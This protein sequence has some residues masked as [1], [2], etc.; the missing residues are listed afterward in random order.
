M[1]S[2]VRISHRLQ[3]FNVLLLQHPSFISLCFI[4]V[5]HTTPRLKKQNF[6]HLGIKSSL[7]SA[8]DMDDQNQFVFDLQLSLEQY[9]D[10]LPHSYIHLKGILVSTLVDDEAHY[11][12]VDISVDFIKRRPTSDL[13]LVFK[14]DAGVK[15]Q[16]GKFKKSVSIYWS[17]DMSV[18]AMYTIVLRY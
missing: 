12:S 4:N 9:D 16:S 7:R 15:H 8:T 1:L 14:D 17:L 5:P 10:H 11:S 18:H 13:E 3:R 6:L 2:H